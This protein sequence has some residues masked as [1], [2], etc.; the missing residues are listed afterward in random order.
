M[1]G[2]NV[3]DEGREQAMVSIDCKTKLAGR[4]GVGTKIFFG[5]INGERVAVESDFDQKTLF[6]QKG[7]TNLREVKTG[8]AND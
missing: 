1:K 2:H 5:K 6:D 4:R 7:P 3:P 8:G